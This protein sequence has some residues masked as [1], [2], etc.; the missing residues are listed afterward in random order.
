MAQCE[1]VG[2][3]FETM[4]AV[5]A[6]QKIP[7]DY[8]TGHLFFHSELDLLEKIH[9]HPN[10]NVS[11]L[12]ALCGV[13]KSA[14]TQI[15]NK[16][17]EKGVIEK[18]NLAKNKKERYFRL[19]KEGETVRLKHQERHEEAAE[20]MRGYLCS[21]TGES[22]AVIIDFM[23][24]MKEYMPVC[25]FPCQYNEQTCQSSRKKGEEKTC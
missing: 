20:E 3:F 17:M 10:C 7:G 11:D 4:Q 1:I 12:S 23:E 14:I 13:S 25:A 21:M 9:Q 16:L 2:R 24:K 5:A 22:K 15:C 8:G 18:Y 19:I 6:E